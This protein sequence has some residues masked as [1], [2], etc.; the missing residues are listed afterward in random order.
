MAA[1]I[2]NGLAFLESVTSFVTMRNKT[3][4]ESQVTGKPRKNR[5]SSTG[6]WEGDPTQLLP[7][8]QHTELMGI[9]SVLYGL[10]LHGAPERP[11]VVRSSVEEPRKIA[12]HALS[13]AGAVLKVLNAVAQMD[14]TLL[15]ASLGAKGVSLEYRHICT[16]LLWY[17]V[18]YNHTC[19]LHEVI[20]CVGYFTI[21]NRNNQDIVNSGAQ[22][23]ILQQLC[24]LPFPYFSNR[25]LM[26]ILFPSLIACCHDN[27][28]NLET[29]EQEAS[30][31]LLA[32]YIE[33]EIEERRSSDV[34]TKQQGDNT[35]P[36]LILPTEFLLSSMTYFKCD[37]NKNR[38]VRK[39]EV[40]TASDVTS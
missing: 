12:N 21:G 35:I 36:D 40:V 23:T 24:L 17:C 29:L 26:S 2:E 34:V 15:Q 28:E 27:R 39:D 20:V 9:I 1:F 25:G 11:T 16:Y 10:L 4:P 33:S 13:V 37:V 8:L 19:L 5:D 30:G 18:H 14:L 7:T 3:S 6:R 32:V 22:P 31:E 38:D